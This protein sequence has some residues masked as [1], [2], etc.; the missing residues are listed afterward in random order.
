MQLRRKHKQE[1]EVSTHS[2]NDIMFFL[3]LFFLIASTM[4]NPNVIKLML[5]SAK[6]N[7]SMT[8]KQISLSVTKDLKYYIDQTPIPFDELR[9]A[10]QNAVG[11]NKEATIVVR[12][13]QDLSV[14]KLVEVL[15]IGNEM[16]LKMILATQKK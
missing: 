15:E 16:K 3:M 4:A 7:Q 13:D 8:K 5:P 10:L 2:L 14:Q 1:S 11:D 9:K 12:M 6:S